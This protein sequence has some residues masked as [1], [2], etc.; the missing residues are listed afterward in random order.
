MGQRVAADV[1]V[2]QVEKYQFRQFGQVAERV[3]L[4]PGA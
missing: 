4:N 2:G 1:G 3:S